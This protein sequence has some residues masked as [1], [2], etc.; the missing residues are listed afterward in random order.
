MYGLKY[1]S[2]PL[3]RRVGGLADTVIDADLATLAE[4]TATGIVF[5]DFTYA[6]YR[7]ALQRAFALY[8]QPTAWRQVRSTG[9]RTPHDWS[10]AAAS[11]TELYRRVA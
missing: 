4:K 11:Y 6:D 10:V 2:V 5:D 9:M 7:H 8:R 1:G 3:V